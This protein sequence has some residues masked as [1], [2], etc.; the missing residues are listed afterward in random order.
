M[1][2][3][4]VSDN[5]WLSFTASATSAISKGQVLAIG[6]DGTVAPAGAGSRYVVGVALNNATA[7]GLV[8]VAVRG[9]VW[10]T[11]GG[12][13]TAGTYVKSAAGG[14]VVAWADY[15]FAST[16]SDTDAEAQAQKTQQILGI[17]LDSASADGDKIR[18]LLKV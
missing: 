7:G 16:Y 12:A 9:V 11:A 15:D 10:V 3:A 18:I 4:W 8:T 14:K 1:G 6:N 17:A 5:L 13:I 2:T